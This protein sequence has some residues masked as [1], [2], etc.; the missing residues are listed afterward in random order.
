MDEIL[1]SLVLFQYY[2]GDANLSRDK[3]LKE[4]IQKDDGW[5]PVATLLTFNRLK[6]L[7]N[8]SSVVV[9]ALEKSTNDLLEVRKCR[10]FVFVYFTFYEM[11]M[12]C[13]LHMDIFTQLRNE[14]N[15]AIRRHPTKPL[16]ADTEEKRKEMQQRLLYVV[17]NEIL[18]FIGVNS[19]LAYLGCFPPFK[20]ISN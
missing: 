20:T 13:V 15:V 9:K 1:T 7:S 17:S 5:V 19:W 3:F 10:N 8:D 14:G 16:P 2:F 12:F 18:C 11:K 4:E 6:A